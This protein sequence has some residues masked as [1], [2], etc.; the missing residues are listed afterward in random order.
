MKTDTNFPSRLLR[1]EKRGAMTRMHVR[2]KQTRQQPETQP[3][4]YDSA[5]DSAQDAGIDSQT[6]QPGYNLTTA[7]DELS[8]GAQTPAQHYNGYPT[9]L[10]GI[11][12][13]GAHV[14]ANGKLGCRAGRWGASQRL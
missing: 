9:S 4:Y 5:S 2:L 3:S 14:A 13:G 8:P 7:L 6:A 10:A 1:T 12:T 11:C